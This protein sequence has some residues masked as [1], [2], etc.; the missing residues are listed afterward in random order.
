MI[1]LE[2][3]GQFLAALKG[4][5]ILAYRNKAFIFSTRHDDVF[6]H[7]I[8][9][10]EVLFAW[11]CGQEVRDVVAQR[12]AEKSGDDERILVKGGHLFTMAAL[13]IVA[14]LRNGAAYLKSL[15]E[16]QI[17]SNTGRE[18]LRK[19]ARYALEAYLGGVK[20]VMEN[21]GK[22][23]PTL[24]RNPDEFARIKER[25]EREYRRSM[26]AGEKYMRDVLPKL[27]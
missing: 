8:R 23:L 24:L 18:R 6:P 26:L 10:E 25:I 4:F 14:T 21:S 2:E 12:R 5:P 19:Y 15:Q 11:V 16:G 17:T 9:V 22:E 7:D 1:K 13:G 27:N 3:V 20:D